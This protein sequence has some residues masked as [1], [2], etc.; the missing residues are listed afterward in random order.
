MRQ[1]ESHRHP[2]VDPTGF[3]RDRRAVEEK[4]PAAIIGHRTEAP[5]FVEGRDLPGMPV[6]QGQWMILERASSN[7]SVAPWSFSS[8]IKVLMSLFGTTVSTA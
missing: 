2:D 6:P 7:M 1:H 5:G 3:V 4:I 8:G